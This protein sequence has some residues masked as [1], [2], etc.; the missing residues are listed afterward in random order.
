MSGAYCRPSGFC[1]I[2][3]IKKSPEFKVLSPELRFRSETSGLGT[4]DSALYLV[5]KILDLVVV[6]AEVV[7][8]FVDH[9]EADFFAEFF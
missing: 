2:F 7:G 1:R 8:D 4:Q 9:R 5:S 3:G 6:H